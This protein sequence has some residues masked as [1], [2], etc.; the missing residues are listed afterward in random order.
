MSAQAILDALRSRGATFDITEEGRLCVEID[1]ADDEIEDADLAMIRLHKEELIELLFLG[2]GVNED[3]DANERAA[4][5][6][7]GCN[8]TVRVGAHDL[9]ETL[10]AKGAKLGV[11]PMGAVVEGVE[12]SDIDAELVRRH[13]RMLSR[14][15]LAGVIRDRT[16]I[17]VEIAEWTGRALPDPGGL[18]CRPSSAYQVTFD[19]LV[20]PSP[21][22]LG[23]WA[24]VM[25][26]PPR[27]HR[28]PWRAAMAF[29][30]TWKRHQATIRRYRRFGKIKPP[31][32][33]AVAG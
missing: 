20:A 6:Q 14:W 31:G 18:G 23:L 22:L 11:H 19:E 24:L 30:R 7:E 16:G 15:I 2:G 9:L 5:Q 28:T 10:K 21:E 33:L 8:L 32:G 26:H 25:D 17:E 4:I 13:D 12:L 1:R 3:Y 27:L 29:L